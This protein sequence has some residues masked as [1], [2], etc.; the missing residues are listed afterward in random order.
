MTFSLSGH[1]AVS[2]KRFWVT[3]TNLAPWIHLGYFCRSSQ[4]V[5]CQDKF[6]RRSSLHLITHKTNQPSTA[7]TLWQ[8]PPQQYKNSLALK[9]RRINSDDKSLADYN[10]KLYKEKRGYPSKLIANQ[11][12][13]AQNNKKS[14]SKNRTVK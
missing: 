7:P 11:I 8:L 2:L 12:Y 6:Q 3:W 10:K 9:G 5:G 1:K 13:A 14:T 4:L